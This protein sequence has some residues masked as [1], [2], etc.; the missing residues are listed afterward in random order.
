MSNRGRVGAAVVVAGA[1]VAAI[2]A[3]S[4][5][6]NTSA[7][8]RADASPFSALWQAGPSPSPGPLRPGPGQWPRPDPEQ[9]RQRQEQFINRLAA[10]LGLSPAQVTEGLKKTRI[11][12]VNQAVTDGKLSREQ[13][14]RIIQQINSGQGPGFGP[15]FGPHGPGPG[16]FGPDGGPGHLPA[17]FV[18]AQALGITP[19]QLHQEIMSG[20]S[21]AEVAQSRGVSRDDLKSKILAAQKARLDA[22]VARGDM[23]AEHAKQVADRF[24]LHIDQMLDFKPGQQPPP[25]R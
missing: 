1:L 22:A 20:K 18:A 6:F 2:V 14:D 19:E 24:A 5:L 8:A 9:I 12:M 10:N 13:A 4:G 25:A 23:T 7:Q 17:T 21:V 3:G 11:D 15:G 16:R